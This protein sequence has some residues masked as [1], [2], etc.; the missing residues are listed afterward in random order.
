MAITNHTPATPDGAYRAPTQA[1]LK[2]APDAD[3]TR[4]APK[5]ATR[6]AS[7]ARRNHEAATLRDD[8]LSVKATSGDHM[9]RNLMGWL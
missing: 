8:T 5:P 2:F 3:D 6:R 9:A 4:S 7:A 1:E